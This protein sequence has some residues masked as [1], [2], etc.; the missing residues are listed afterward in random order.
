MEKRDS[1]KDVLLRAAKR[2]EQSGVLTEKR[3]ALGDVFLRAAK[4]EQ[5]E[6]SHEL[7]RS[8][9]RTQDWEYII[10]R[11][12]ILPKPLSLTFGTEEE[13]DVYV[14]RREQMLDAGIL[15]EDLVARRSDL[16]SVDDAIRSYMA[17][18]SLPS[19]DAS[20]L[21]AL[22]DRWNGQALTDVDYQ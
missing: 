18:V 2:S 3:D 21:N 13:G 8:G 16:V 22:V 5:Q 14:K 20:L 15:P 4:R 6:Q 10:R 17:K 19:S 11:K 1:L 9:A 7:V 12:G